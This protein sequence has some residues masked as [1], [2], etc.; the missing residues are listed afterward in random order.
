MAVNRVGRELWRLDLGTP[1]TAR[2]VIGWDGRV[3]IPAG[4]LIYCRTAS[5]YALWRR[6][7][8]SAISVAPVLDHMG[9]IAMALENREFI[10]MDQFGALE[11]ISLDRVPALIVPLKLGDE[12]SYFVI[13]ASGEA[14]R[15]VLNAGARSGAT[16]SRSRLPAL[17]E[18]PAAAVGRDDKV[19]VTLRDGRVLLLSGITG[20]VQWRGNSHEAAVEKGAG[21]L[22]LGEAAMHFDERGIFV[23]TP[24]GAVGFAADGRRRWIHRI[25][26]AS[27]IPVLSDEG[28]LYTCGDDRYIRTYKVESRER[29]VPRSMYGP[30]PEGTYGLGDPPASPWANDDRRFEADQIKGMYELIDQATRNGQVGERETAFVGYL[31][32]MTGGLL[33]SASYSLVRPPIHVPQR[34]EFI[35]LLA[36]MGSRETIPFLMNLF[37]RDGEP[38]IKAACCEA[39][40]RI[41]VDPRGD[42]IRAYSVLL[43][44][45][46]ANRD[47]MT[48]MAATSSIAT[49]CRFS[50]PPLAIEGIRLLAVF[51]RHPDFPPRIRQQAQTELNA[52]RREGLDKVIE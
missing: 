19:A 35:K 33:N 47:P 23:L 4:D 34:V 26:N 8:G 49:L 52:L 42:A 39:I 10:R 36:R 27:T 43:A 51:S 17:P 46:N 1:I 9:G 24:R 40:A 25:E 21:N 38:S 5:G 41:G 31:M 15:I 37:Y 3:F 50:G 29:N 20:L 22:S 6:E 18:A 45:D 48:L 7:L 32:E 11:R 12:H 30:Q 16:L 44:P 13:Y 14:E 2:A 28:L